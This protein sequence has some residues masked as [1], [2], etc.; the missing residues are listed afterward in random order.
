MRMVS[1]LLVKWLAEWLNWR[2][3][4]DRKST[5]L[6]SNHGYIS[7]AVFCLKKKKNLNEYSEST[8]HVD[9]LFQYA[10]T[11][12]APSSDL[13]ASALRH[14]AVERLTRMV[15]NHAAPESC[16]AI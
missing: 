12:A 1:T 5:R 6:N 2:R 11:A 8:T 15:Q 9:R 10:A 3:M 4:G 7:Y 13:S 16:T 14:S